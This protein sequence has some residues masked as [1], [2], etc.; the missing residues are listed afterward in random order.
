MNIKDRIGEEVSKY[1]RTYGHFPRS[2]VVSKRT[3]EKLRREW[4]QYKDD[5]RSAI[6]G[7]HIEVKSKQKVDV[8]LTS[9]YDNPAWEIDLS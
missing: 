9:P 3:Y 7:V 1:S 6:K 8:V 5:E 4:P 2:I